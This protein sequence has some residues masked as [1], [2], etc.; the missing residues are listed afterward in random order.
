MPNVVEI[1]N[2]RGSMKANTET[3][4]GS[5]IPIVTWFDKMVTTLS[6]NIGRKP[7]FK[8]KTVIR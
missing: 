4:E 5:Q 3:V 6:I 8:T 1:K 2:R 7:E